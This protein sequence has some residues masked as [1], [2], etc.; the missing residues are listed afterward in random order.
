MTAAA[1]DALRAIADAEASCNALPGSF[2]EGWAAA[3][4]KL[5][6]YAR[7]ALAAHD[8]AAAACPYRAAGYRDR[9][10]YLQT[11]AEDYGPMTLY[12]ADILGPSEDFDGLVTA[13]EDF[14]DSGD[15]DAF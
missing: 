15:L 8:V 1:L 4:R 9:A 5:A 3:H 14:A 13:L 2:G 7:A 11:L 10:D 6:A 12:L